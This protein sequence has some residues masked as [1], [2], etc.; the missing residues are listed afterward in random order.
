MK[1]TRSRPSSHHAEVPQSGEG[2]AGEAWHSGTRY[3]LLSPP[4]EPGF[5]HHG[6]AAPS[7]GTARWGEAG[8]ASSA[9]DARGRDGGQGWRFLVP[10]A[11]PSS[12]APPRPR[13]WPVSPSPGTKWAFSSACSVRLSGQAL[14][15]VCPTDGCSPRLPKEAAL[16][17]ETFFFSER[18]FS[19]RFVPSQRP[20][21][22]P[23]AC[24]RAVPLKRPLLYSSEIL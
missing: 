19:L 5:S 8:R 11:V 23:P 10:H 12:P 20:G 18:C 2:G 3:F 9:G 6:D 4:N 1:P 14:G 16:G 21:G 15:S 22:K 13:A 24:H 7:D 17:G